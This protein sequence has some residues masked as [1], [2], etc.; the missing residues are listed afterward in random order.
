MND[1]TND[2]IGTLRR[3]IRK[4]ETDPEFSDDDIKALRQIADAFKGLQAFGRLAKWVIFLLAAVAGA[5]SAW[6]AIMV[7]VRAWVGG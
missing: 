6:E 1:W 4:A 2:E 7:K 5:F 3:I